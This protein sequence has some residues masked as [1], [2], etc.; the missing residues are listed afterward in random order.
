MSHDG[1][2]PQQTGS[3]GPKIAAFDLDGTL[4]TTASGKTFSDDPIDWKWWHPSVPST[5]RSLWQ[6]DGY[7]IVIFSNQG[8]LTLDPD[9]KPTKAAKDIKRLDAWKEKIAMV[10]AQLDLPVS[11]Y[12]ATGKDSFRKPSLGMWKAMCEDFEDFDAKVDNVDKERSFFVGDAGGRIPQPKSAG[13]KAIAKDFSCSDRNFAHNVGI[14]FL[15]PE[16]FFLD[17]PARPFRRAFDLDDYPCDLTAESG[18]QFKKK[19]DCELVVFC[20]PP[21]A[22]KSLFYSTYLKDLGYVRVNQDILKSRDNCVKA[23]TK[24]LMAGKSVAIDSTNPAPETRK[25]WTDLAKGM[26]K[27]L[28]SELEVVPRCVWFKT[29]VSVA[30]HNNRVRAANP[31]LNPE[32]R[33]LVPKMA[34]NSFASRFK[35]PTMDSED[36]KDILEVDFQFRGDPDGHAQWNRYYE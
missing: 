15:T 1:H 32:D 33:E 11:L 10:L 28:P 12:A 17:E 2:D 3:H 20:G 8:G 5:L 22:G 21:G 27:K 7:K 30:E 13:K 36:F 34:F 18:M 16:E 24:A 25:V 26:S 4:I 19:W 23:A 29:P 9:P 14:K 6:K 35:A 31:S